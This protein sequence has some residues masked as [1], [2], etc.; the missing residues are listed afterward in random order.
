MVAHVMK[1]LAKGSEQILG[2]VEGG[3]NGRFWLKSVDKKARFDTQIG[4]V[5]DAKAGEL[6]M[7]ELT[8]N[9]HKKICTGDASARRSVCTK[10]FQ[11]DCYP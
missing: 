6:V 4:D 7:A 10:E 8:G 2:V 9:A 11:P 1:K 3:E 5:G